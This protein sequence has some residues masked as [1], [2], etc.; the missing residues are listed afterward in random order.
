MG[1]F[2]GL[3]GA[4]KETRTQLHIYDDGSFEFRRKPL[5]D[6]CIVEERDTLTLKAWPHF[7]AAELPFRGHK[8]IQADMVTMS[9]DRDFILDPFDKIPV[10]ETINGKPER[11]ETS[12]KKW[13]AQIAES[14]RYKVMSKPGSTLLVDKI[15][16]FL[17]AGFIL[18]V[19]AFAISKAGG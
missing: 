18:I 2:S 16:M 17:G 12:I 4:P 1:L 9:F 13:T 8:K 5:K 6:A 10:S 19:I 15:T 7:Y 11:K 3:V 14:Q